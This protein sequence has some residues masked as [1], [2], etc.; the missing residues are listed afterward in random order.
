M[1]PYAESPIHLI[2]CLE[3]A[4]SSGGGG[5]GR[6]VPGQETEVHPYRRLLQH[7]RELAGG[8]RADGHRAEQELVIIAGDNCAFLEAFWASV[9]MGSTA[10]PLPAPKS[11]GLDVYEKARLE[12]VATLLPG[13]QFLVEDTYLDA[14]AKAVPTTVGRSFG[15][16]EITRRQ[17]TVVNPPPR[18]DAVLLHTSG[19]SGQPNLVRL[20]HANL[21]AAASGITQATGQLTGH[22]AVNWLPLTQVSGLVRS[23]REIVVGGTQLH[24]APQHVIQRPTYWLDCIHQFRAS[25]SWSAAFGYGLLC[26]HQEEVRAG[27]WDLSCLKSL[28]SFGE[29]LSQKKMMEVVGLLAEHGFRESAFQHGWGMTETASTVVMCTSANKG[30]TSNFA[31]SGNPIGDTQ[32][33]IVGE[34]GKPTTERGHLQV[35][36]SSVMVGYVGESESNP[37]TDDGWLDTGDLATLGEAGLVV[38]GRAKNVVIV[39][40]VTYPSQDLESALTDLPGIK[41]H[42]VCAYREP[43]VDTDSIVVFL[44]TNGASVEQDALRRLV[45]RKLLSKTGVP[46]KQVMVVVSGFPRTPTGKVK[47]QALLA[48]LTGGAQDTMIE[49]K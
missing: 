34:D 45:N 40:G 48:L 17:G 28:Q 16:G 42:V 24:T 7:A 46:A 44:E 49:S 41:S 30:S 5:Y 43:T 23:L 47:R 38:V 32:L 39:N 10:V 18:T 1:D 31:S 3:R 25:S 37:F 6:L 13:A 15:I 14:I 19:T 27:S 36:G 8:L 29:A 20:S 2:E 11:R 4:A 21:I 12:R 33:R 22:V 26:R 35:K 9:A